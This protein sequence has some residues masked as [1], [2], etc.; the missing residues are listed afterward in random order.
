MTPRP[1]A[2]KLIS[3]SYFT[4]LLWND[5]D[6]EMQSNIISQ[7]TDAGDR[8]VGRVCGHWV[9]RRGQPHDMQCWNE[10]ATASVRAPGAAQHQIL[11]KI[12]PLIHA[13]G[14]HRHAGKSGR[15]RGGSRGCRA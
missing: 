4:L 6:F 8:T 1:P 9:R 12:P 13:A 11:L 15:R 2:G 10:D 14:T 7:S 5:Q 3:P